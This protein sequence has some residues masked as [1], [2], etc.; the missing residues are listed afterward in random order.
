MKNS[1][2]GA[3]RRKWEDNITMDIQVVRWVGIGSVNMVQNRKRYP[4]VVMQ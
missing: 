4:A 2:T 1:E 3:A